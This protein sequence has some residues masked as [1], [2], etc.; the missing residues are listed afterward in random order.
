MEPSESRARGAAVDA[1]L[2][3]AVIGDIH[4]SWGPLDR[5][6]FN[7]SDYD[8]LLFVGDLPTLRL[9]QVYAI[10]RSIA[11]LAKPAYLV[12]GNHDAVTLFQLVAEVT[13]IFLPSPLSG[14]RQAARVAALSRALGSVELCGYSRHRL[15]DGADGLGMVVGRPH[16]MG[17]RL[18]F[19]RYLRRRF[20]I[21][22]LEASATRICQLVDELDTPRLLFLAHNGP[23]GLGDQSADIWGCD[24]KKGAGD[25]GDPDL[26]QA[27]DYAVR[28]G[29]TVV[30]VVAGHMHHRTK[31]GEDRTWLLQRDGITYVNAARSPR[32]FRVDGRRMRHH[33]ALEIDGDG[34]R[35]EEVLVEA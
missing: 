25:W 32:V 2:R 17:G 27:V 21:T 6:Y 29:R 23:S 34:C 35:V 26:R 7:R 30:A 22:S 28:S 4:A 11:S 3:L 9:G 10:A 19:A 8:A 18:N 1:P 5:E 31:Q 14:R 16:S 12:P 13:G 15:V 33:V 20:G 24:F